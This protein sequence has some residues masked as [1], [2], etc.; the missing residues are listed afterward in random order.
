MENS[1]QVL[2]NS[3]FKK[4]AIAVLFL[5]FAQLFFVVFSPIEVRAEDA[6]KE[7]K[8]ESAAENINVEL[9]VPLPFVR[10]GCES[11]GAPAVCNLS[12]YIKGVYRLLLGA[13][14]LFAVVM[15]IIAGYQ[16]MISGGSSDRIGSAK[17]RIFGAS[18]GLI[19]MLLAYIVLNA[20]S[21][22]LVELRLPHIKPIKPYTMDFGLYCQ[23]DDV[24]STIQKELEK[25][26]EAGGDENK[27][28][29]LKST[30]DN[31]NFNTKLE[32]AQCGFS[33]IVPGGKIE[34][35]G[36]FCE[37]TKVC[38][39][40][41]GK[42]QCNEAIVYGKVNWD[43][44]QIPPFIKNYL[45]KVEVY[46]LCSTPVGIHPVSMTLIAD[47]SF[48][49]KPNDYFVTYNE[50]DA[51]TKAKDVAVAIYT[52]GLAGGYRVMDDKCMVGTFL[53]YSIVAYTHDYP[54]DNLYVLDRNCVPFAIG[55]WYGDMGFKLINSEALKGVNLITLN[56]LQKGFKCDIDLLHPGFEDY[57]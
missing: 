24:N 1:N 2:K 22:R 48:R 33:Y 17:K 42:D 46:K 41:D 7:E 28:L 26:K 30:P 6:K 39:T 27:F 54:M 4:I 5:V 16:W 9:K 50:P 3:F 53:G 15:I 36:T 37:G 52:L 51:L 31:L 56:E 20:V 47:K 40:A 8:Q 49:G 55:G 13:G 34:C 19:L 21:S 11:D 35:K 38:T 12:D 25:F 10:M 18:M 43:K 14:A 57:D 29:A 23:T 44:A 32:D 45:K